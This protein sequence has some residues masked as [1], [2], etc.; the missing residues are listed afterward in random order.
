MA[1]EQPK[2]KRGRADHLRP[3]QWKPGESGNPGGRP[4][5]SFSLVNMAK[6]LL[7]EDPNALREIV[8]N[9]VRQ[10]AKTDEKSLGFIR[11]L[12]DRVDGPVPT[13]VQGPDGG[14][15]ELKLR[16]PDSRFEDATK[17]IADESGDEGEGNGHGTEGT[18]G[19]EA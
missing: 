4:T 14:P 9:W 2:K 11:T 5:G 7:A 6:K 17:Q 18:A 16:W 1:D 10:A 8:E 13:Q 19:D 15:V 12:L 3:F